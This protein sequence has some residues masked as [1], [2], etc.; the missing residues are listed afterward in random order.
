MKPLDQKY[1]I[2]RRQNIVSVCSIDPVT[3][4]ITWL[5]PSNPEFARTFFD[6]GH[7]DSKCQRLAVAILLDFTGDDLIAFHLNA[8]FTYDHVARWTGASV[9]IDG[10]TIAGWID[11]HQSIIARLKLNREGA[12]SVK[13]GS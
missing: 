1:R 10:A 4:R 9:E 11:G 12:K 13:V 8:A 2:Q 5:G 7:T 6:M 3:E